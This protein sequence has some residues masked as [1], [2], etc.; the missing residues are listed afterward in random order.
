MKLRDG[1]LLVVLVLIFVILAYLLS[2]KNPKRPNSDLFTVR[3]VVKAFGRE[4]PKLV[5]GSKVEANYK[6]KG[7]WYK[8]KI[9]WA[10]A[11]GTYD[12]QYDDF[13]IDALSKDA[14]ERRMGRANVHPVAGAKWKKR[15]KF[16]MVFKTDPLLPLGVE[17]EPRQESKSGPR[18]LFRQPNAFSLMNN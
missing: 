3:A 9:T 16:D 18:L 4:R 11:D 6:G 5:R 13:Q 10:H 1:V 14:V 12:V 2:S 15:G 8:G 17:V 7:K